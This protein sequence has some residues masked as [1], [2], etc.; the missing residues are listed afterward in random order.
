MFSSKL[1]KKQVPFLIGFIDGMLTALSLAAGKLFEPN[2]HI[3]LMLALRVACVSLASSG[4]VY[5]VATY[6]DLRGQLV[7]AEKELNLTKSGQ[8]AKSRLGKKVLVQSTLDAIIS[9]VSGFI[10]SLIPLG[11]AIVVPNWPW[12]AIA[13]SSFILGSLGY[14]LGRCVGRSPIIWALAL[15]LGG[16]LIT[17][18]GFLLHIV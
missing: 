6:T 2:D 8:L 16:L 1:Q 7:H 10:G 5:F 9:G 12:I 17:Y 18:I 3:T 11:A 13:F 14:I 15:A 4:F